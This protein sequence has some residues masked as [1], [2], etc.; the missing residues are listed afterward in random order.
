MKKKSRLPNPKAAKPV[1]QEHKTPDEKIDFL[2]EMN[3]LEAVI[4]TKLKKEL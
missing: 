1:Q 3:K 4:L 2:L